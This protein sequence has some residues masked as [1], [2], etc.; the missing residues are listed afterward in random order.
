MQAFYPNTACTIPFL[1]FWNMIWFL[2][3]IIVIHQL[4]NYEKMWMYFINPIHRGTLNHIFK[5]ILLKSIIT[6][7]YY[8][9]K[10]SF[11]SM[12]FFFQIFQAGLVTKI[13]MPNG[14]NNKWWQFMWDN[15]F[16]LE[17]LAATDN[18]TILP[19][20]RYGNFYFVLSRE[21]AKKTLKPWIFHVSFT[22]LKTNSPS[23]GN[24][25]LKNTIHTLN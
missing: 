15:R 22:S 25:P 6:C 10:L 21:M 5:L 24:S 14:C 11:T 17:N 4:K 9:F 19:R 18:L 16:F 23:C 7:I 20:S 1:L 13:P 3:S 2:D 12:V 8:K